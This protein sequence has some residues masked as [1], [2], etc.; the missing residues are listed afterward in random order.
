[1]RAL[2]LLVVVEV[3]YAAPCEDALVDPIATPIRETDQQRGAC[4]RDQLAVD[5]TTHALVDTPNFH[6]V[7]GGDLTLAGRFVLSRIELGARLRLV[8]YTY[9]QTAVNKVTATRSGPLAI[10]AAVAIDPNLAA[11]A[12]VELP[13]TRDIHRA[14]EIDTLHTSGQVGLAFTSTL[15]RRLTVHARL[16]GGFAYA[17]SS[18]GDTERFALRAGT[19]LVWQPGRRL[20]VQLGTDMEAGWRDGFSTLLARGGVAVRI[21]AHRVNLGIGIPLAGDEPTTAVVMLGVARDL[22]A[23]ARRSRRATLAP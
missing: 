14:R 8:D 23:G 9:V 15:S 5:L 10:G 18:G 1:M 11:I 20:A 22:D 13:F 3:A 2:A 19:E 7:L 12:L 6:G 16:G 21:G 4:L 17:S